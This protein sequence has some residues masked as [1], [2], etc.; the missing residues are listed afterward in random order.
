MRWGRVGGGGSS[1]SLARRSGVR[2][3]W[4]GVGWS[5]VGLS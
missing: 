2:W 1:T 5:V 3:G 4:G